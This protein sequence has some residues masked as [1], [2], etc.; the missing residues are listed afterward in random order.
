MADTRNYR[1]A[2][3]SRGLR[4]VQLWLPDP[5]SPEFLAECARQA[6]IVRESERDASRAE[7][8]LWLPAAD[9]AGW[10]E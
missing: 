5:R 2:L 1:E 3:R 7:D 8:E 6:R 9:F 10:M 4:P